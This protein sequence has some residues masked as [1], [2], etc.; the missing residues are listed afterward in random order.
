[1]RY[2]FLL[3]VSFFCIGA[4]AQDLGPLKI[5]INPGHGGNDA[6]DR[7]IV[8]HPFKQGD[9]NGFWESQSN[10][11]KGFF[12]RDYL[13]A[14]EVTVYMSRTQNRTVD[15]LPLSDI[16][17]MANA[18]NVD[19][20]FSIHSNAHNGR[21]NYP[22]MLFKGYD[23][24]PV[25]PGDK[26]M[27]E[28]CWTNFFAQKITTWTYP[29]MNVRGDWSFYGGTSGLGVLRN[30]T[31]E[32]ILSEGSF[33]DYIPETYRLM[34]PMYKKLEAWS[35]M[36][37]IYNYFGKGAI[38]TGNIA[39]D[40]RDSR[41]KLNV[42]YY[43]VPGRDELIPIHSAKVTLL[44]NNVEIRTD[45]L[46]NGVYLFDEL[47]PG[48]Y[49]LKI[50][51]EGYRDAL[52]DVTVEADKTTYAP[53]SLDRVRDTAPVVVSYSPANSVIDSVECNVPVVVDFN[54]DMDEASIESAFSITPA[55]SGKITFE[56]SQ[57]RMIFTPDKP[58]EKATIYTVKIDKSAK[59]PGDISMQDDF[60]FQFLTKNRN[61]LTLLESFPADN[62]QNVYVKSNFRF[63]FDKKLK[64]T[65]LADSIRV[66]DKD[67]NILSKNVRS[68]SNNKVDAPYG[69]A[70][71]DLGSDLVAGE[72][73]KVIISGNVVDDGEMPLVDPIEI[74]FVAQANTI[75]GKDVVDNFETSATYAF[76]AENSS[77]VNSASAS[78]S[79]TQKLFD[80]YSYAY[81]YSLNDKLGLVSYKLNAPATQV[82]NDKVMGLHIYG[83]FSFNDV[84]LNFV[85]ESNVSYSVKLKQL[86][87]TGWKYAETELTSLPVG[88]TYKFAGIDLKGTNHVLSA[89]GTFYVDN[90]LLYD[91]LV[92]IDNVNVTDRIN[93]LSNMEIGYFLV[94]TPDGKEI[95]DLTLLSM[96]GV[97]VAKS[98]SNV[99]STKGLPTG[100]Y[101]L[102]IKLDDK[103][104]STIVIVN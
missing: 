89:S 78:R 10:L 90:L 60:S 55:V 74:N 13:T 52:I 103:I 58:L 17:E 33:H 85:D 35:F 82:T 51:A 24:Q 84:Y 47:A 14:R 97:T 73:Y 6:D 83:D 32:G 26:V 2:L 91:E 71:F 23:D 39:G 21:V 79:T 96:N 22:L 80:S 42:S 8:I 50:E 46:Y 61:R 62:D 81:T 99:I 67:G 95:S 54:W 38:S 1:M 7:N 53:I 12:L 102:K 19:F 63:V 28:F 93:I 98:Q 34:S 11:D 76:S 88:K 30:L 45:T 87:F 75:T 100:T 36:K 101:V 31:V 65:N 5:F 4:I 44:P 70:Y 25:K 20:F 18:N 49:Q 68:Q 3:C 57:Y 92:S 72:Q 77:G 40:I 27:A 59:H 104:K 86:D 29:S 48:T 66:V 43:I 16:S 15:D 41:V 94:E 64:T 37:S 69:S 9:P 56:D